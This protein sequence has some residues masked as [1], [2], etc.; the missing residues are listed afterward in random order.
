M[1]KHY[2]LCCEQYKNELNF[3]SLVLAISYFRER[4]LMFILYREIIFM[5][6]YIVFQACAS[7]ISPTVLHYLL[8]IKKII[9]YS[10]N[11]RIFWFCG[12]KS[13]N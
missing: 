12:I 13:E 4:S 10:Q 11:S 3:Y 5:S 1:K 2:N 9:F 7:F 6:S 8:E